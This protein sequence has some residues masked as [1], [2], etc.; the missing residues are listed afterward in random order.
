MTMLVHRPDCQ[1]CEAVT[2]YAAVATHSSL[3]GDQLA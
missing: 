1:S 3:N 2:A